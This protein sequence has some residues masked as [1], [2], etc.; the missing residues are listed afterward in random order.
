V[1]ISEESTRPRTAAVS[2]ASVLFCVLRT[3]PNKPSAAERSAN[4]GAALTITNGRSAV[5]KENKHLAV[6]WS[7]Q[8][9]RD[10]Y[11]PQHLG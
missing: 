6:R 7:F 1:K 8:T 10:G 5:V 11:K 4:V 3:V 2:T 9:A